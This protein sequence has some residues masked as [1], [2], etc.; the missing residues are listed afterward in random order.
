MRF[1]IKFGLIIAAIV[2]TMFIVLLA[3]L[4]SSPLLKPGASQLDA[5]TMVLS[6]LGL[7]AVVF[8]AMIVLAMV[9]SAV[10]WG[11]WLGDFKEHQTSDQILDERYAK[12]DISYSQYM[13]LK[14][15]IENARRK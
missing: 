11:Q 1:R 6:I 9:I 5:V 15:N 7:F 8:V 12:G 14:N 10:I 3:V 2:V 13:M 4:F